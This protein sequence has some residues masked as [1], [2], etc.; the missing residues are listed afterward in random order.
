VKPLGFGI[1]MAIEARAKKMEWITPE[2]A[3]RGSLGAGPSSRWAQSRAKRYFD[4][5]VVLVGLPLVAPVCLLIGI[6][7]RLNSRGPILFRQIR[8]GMEGRPFLIVKFRTMHHSQ[9]TRSGSIT[10]LGD[11]QITAVGR[12]L[13]YWKLDELP[14]LLNVLRGEMSLVGPRPRVPEQPLGRVDCLPGI[15]GAASLVFARE[16]ILLAGIPRRELDTYYARRVIPVK[17]Q[18]DDEYMARAT[19]L[20][21]LKLIFLSI[22][23]VWFAAD[24]V[25]PLLAGVAR[26]RQESISVALPGEACD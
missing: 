3:R 26:D 5:A 7:I 4:I 19:F 10:I 22:F 21:D 18:L 15:T 16:E 8:I 6:A 14:Q 13:R 9:R 25:S 11:R 20:S 23:R 24:R 2:I 1:R 17:Q 12:V